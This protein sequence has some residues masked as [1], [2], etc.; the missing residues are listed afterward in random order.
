MVESWAFEAAAVPAKKPLGWSLR[1]GFG[2]ATYDKATLTSFPAL[3]KSVS[4]TTTPNPLPAVY[5]SAAAYDSDATIPPLPIATPRSPPADRDAS[6]VPPKKRLSTASA[7]S[8]SSSTMLPAKKRPIVTAEDV[9][10]SATK[11]IKSSGGGTKSKS[12]KKRPPPTETPSASAP[13]SAAASAAKTKK[14]RSSTTKST[15]KSTGERTALVPLVQTPHVDDDATSM[16]APWTSPPDAPL[17][18]EHHERHNPRSKRQRWRPLEYWKGER[19]VYEAPKDSPAPFARITSV[20]I[21]QT[22]E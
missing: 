14:R 10:N 11:P 17:L 2:G 8:G 13:A 22:T 5:R 6:M 15:G 1:Q 9:F 19:V 12:S 20:L 21:R 4:L 16:R 3:Q 7:A 18:L